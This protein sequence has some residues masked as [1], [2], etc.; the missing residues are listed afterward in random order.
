MARVL[1]PPEQATSWEEF[2]E[3]FQREQRA[4]DHRVRSLGYGLTMA[5][6]MLLLII[7]FVFLVYALGQINDHKSWWQWLGVA[8]PV[9]I[10]AAMLRRAWRRGRRDG[11][12]RRELDA[13]KANWE[14]R[15][16][17]GEIPRTRAEAEGRIS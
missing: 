17:R 9:A 4:I 12:R 16:A 14:Q 3:R 13:L 15:V 6:G 2:D 5:I 11:Q 10:V 1:L 7:A 8:V